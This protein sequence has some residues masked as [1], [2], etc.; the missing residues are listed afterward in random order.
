L[1][2]YKNCEFRFKKINIDKIKPPVTKPL[3]LGGIIHTIMEKL[4]KKDPLPSWEEAIAMELAQNG[5]SIEDYREDLPE[6]VQMLEAGSNNFILSSENLITEVKQAYTPAWNSTSWFNK[7]TMFRGIID[8]YSI[9]GSTA[10][11]VD[12]KT[13]SAVTSDPLQTEIYAFMLFNDHP[14]LTTVMTTIEYLKLGVSI[15]N[16]Y[17]REDVAHL[18]GWLK[19]LSEEIFEKTEDPKY[20]WKATPNEFCGW[21]HLQNECPMYRKVHEEMVVNSPNMLISELSDKELYAYSVIA[22]KLASDMSDELSTRLK[23]SGCLDISD[24]KSLILKPRNYS[25]VNPDA[26]EQLLALGV[27]E[28]AIKGCTKLSVSAMKGLLKKHEVAFKD[29]ADKLV[30]KEV[31]YVQTVV[32]KS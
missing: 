2:D 3:L 21:C 22:G 4:I 10:Y 7:N 18:K 25:N 30:T 24:T 31:R 16:M 20:E 13:S 17:S 19:S 23:E 14:E 12:W 29:V 26:W 9:I 1:S 15:E 32:Q 27:P 5:K 28:E 8:V 11:V 6:L